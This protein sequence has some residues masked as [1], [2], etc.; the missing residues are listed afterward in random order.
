MYSPEESLQTV[1]HV[2]SCGR[3]A[4][5]YRLIV[6]DGTAGNGGNS[7]ALIRETGT[8]S[9]INM[10]HFAMNSPAALTLNRERLTIKPRGTR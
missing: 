2:G 8:A 10:T 4:R 3:G 9:E 6:L 7:A 5:L 1:G